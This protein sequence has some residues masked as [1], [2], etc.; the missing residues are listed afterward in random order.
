MATLCGAK[1]V[2]GSSSSKIEL[3]SAGERSELA[4]ARALAASPLPVLDARR[5]TCMPSALKRRSA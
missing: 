5:S 2:D 1:P 4:R 3:A